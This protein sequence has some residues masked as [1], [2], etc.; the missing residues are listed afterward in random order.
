[1]FVGKFGALKEFRMMC[2]M[3]INQAVTV[4]QSRMLRRVR[5]IRSKSAKL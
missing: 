4:V 1:M 2:R 5:V 3:N